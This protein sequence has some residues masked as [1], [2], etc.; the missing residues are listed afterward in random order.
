[1]SV[2]VKRHYE[3][4]TDATLNWTALH[5]FF[6]EDFVVVGAWSDGLFYLSSVIDHL[7]TIT[8]LLTMTSP[9]LIDGRLKDMIIDFIVTDIIEWK[10]G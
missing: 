7:I 8:P 3:T 5:S 9:G 2:E 10:I 6:A 1:M 4:G